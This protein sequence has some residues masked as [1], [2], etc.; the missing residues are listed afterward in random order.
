VVVILEMLTLIATVRAKYG[1]PESALV[2]HRF[3]TFS[4]GQDR[5]LKK[6]VEQH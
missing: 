6:K 4:S 3:F 1:G 5:N 2:W